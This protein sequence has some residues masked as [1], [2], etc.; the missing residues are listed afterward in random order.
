SLERR[1]SRLEGRPFA[2][3]CRAIAQGSR[4]HRQA[5]TLTDRSFLEYFRCP[6]AMAAI[7]A[8]TGLSSQDGFF[9]F[10]DVIA[11]GRFAGGRPASHA[12]D[13]LTDISHCVIEQERTARLP[14]DLSEVATNLRQERYPQNGHN[15]L[16]KTTSGD[17]AQRLYYMLR[18][19]MGVAIRKH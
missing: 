3:S 19:F 17:A 15:F 14:F 2:R 10:Q 9:R 12:T 6:P 5:L 7:D 16:Q 4:P 13:D 8:Q 11:F 18:P 1:R